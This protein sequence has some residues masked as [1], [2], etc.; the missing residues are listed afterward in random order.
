MKFMIER[1]RIRFNSGVE[2]NGVRLVDDEDKFGNF[3]FPV[4][5]LEQDEFENNAELIRG[6][7]VGSFGSISTTIDAFF[8][9]ALRFGDG[10]EIDGVRI[11]GQQLGDA[12]KS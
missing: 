9:A 12:L 4:L 3:Y 1:L 11:G 8:K 5:D 7:H 10:L 2:A 6:L